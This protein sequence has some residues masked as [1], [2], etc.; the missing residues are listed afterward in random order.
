MEGHFMKLHYFPLSSYS[1]KTLI[2]F[3]EKNVSF[4]PEIVDVRDAA[5]RERYRRLYPLGKI[6]MLIAD[7]GE[8]ISESSIIIE[9]IDHYFPT[10]TR[11]I[12]DDQD[13]ARQTRFHDRNADLYLNE[14]VTTLHSEGIKPDA[15]R[16]GAAIEKARFRLGIMDDNLDRHRSDKTWIM[17]DDFTMAD[18]ATA[19]ALQYAQY[20]APFA[21][22]SNIAAYWH[23]LETR[24]SFRRVLDEAAPY[25]REFKAASGYR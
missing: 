15:Q 24:P 3:A 21:S 14:S 20:V 7:D 4:I 1:Q 6:P 8:T 16:N 23:R 18:C 11:L 22:R 17:G 13:R 12:P 9:Y 5:V 19:P 25:L 2:A 10:G